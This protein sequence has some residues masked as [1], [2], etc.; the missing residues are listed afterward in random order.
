MYMYVLMYMYI[1]VYI[2]SV[3][4][5][6][7][8]SSDQHSL[9]YTVCTV[10][11][12]TRPSLPPASDRPVTFDPI[13][14]RA[15]VCPV[16]FDP[17]NLKSHRAI[18]CERRE[19]GLERCHTH[20]QTVSLLD[21]VELLLPLSLSFLGPLPLLLPHPSPLLPAAVLARVPPRVDVKGEGGCAN[22]EGVAVCEGV[23]LA[24]LFRLSI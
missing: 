5:A 1:H 3:M 7:V 8:M 16:T 9:T 11:T 24:A 22:G 23:G 20:P 17:L 2:T 15:C 4:R 18:D 6:P 19:R 10:C 14:L 12:F 13:K 21:S